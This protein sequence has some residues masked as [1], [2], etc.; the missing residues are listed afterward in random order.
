MTD[1]MIANSPIN[2]LHSGNLRIG[3]S[4]VLRST[5]T[6]VLLMSHL[7]GNLIQNAPLPS[8]KPACKQQKGT[9]SS[10]LMANKTWP[11]NT[12][13]DMSADTPT[14]TQ[15]N[16]QTNMKMCELVQMSQ[17]TWCIMVKYICHYALCYRASICAPINVTPLS[18]QPCH[19]TT[20]SITHGITQSITESHHHK[21]ALRY[22]GVLMP[23]CHLPR[24]TP[25]MR[26]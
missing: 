24:A 19:S 5:A 12:S 25:D 7:A 18:W 4:I 1:E 26:L 6:L 10:Q 23:V 21:Q 8:H 20:Q 14:N 3:S 13:A 2:D 16:I 9:T 11:T 17:R 15:I 22:A